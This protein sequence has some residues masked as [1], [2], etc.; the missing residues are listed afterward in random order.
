MYS[1]SADS[2][3][4]STF[5]PVVDTACFTSGK[6]RDLL[7]I[8]TEHMDMLAIQDASSR[9]LLRLSGPSDSQV[10]RPTTESPMTV[11]LP[12]TAMV[13]AP[14]LSGLPVVTAPPVTRWTTHDS[15]SDDPR[16]NISLA[17]LEGR[18]PPGLFL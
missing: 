13:T 4:S 12:T 14:T 9:Q 5:G 10:A 6:T 8:L 16:E 18:R 2:T 1:A 3:D 11:V 17:A 15:D 7:K